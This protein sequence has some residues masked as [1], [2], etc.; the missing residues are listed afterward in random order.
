[1][2]FEKVAAALAEKTGLD[3][4]DIKPETSFQDLKLDSLDTVDVLMTLEDVFNV[5]L[6]M[7]TELKCV[8][9]VVTQ[10][11]QLVAQK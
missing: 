9:D 10:I 1:M 11:D 6:E 3:V 2:T 7:S 4:S 5:Q 8:G